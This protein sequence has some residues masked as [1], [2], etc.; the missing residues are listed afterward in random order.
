[1]V[2]SPAGFVTTTIKGNSVD[3]FDGWGT[4]GRLDRAVWTWQ[5]SG[6]I[7]GPGAE[8]NTLKAST[9]DILLSFPSQ[10]ATVIENN[11]INGGGITVTEPNSGGK[12]DI[13]DNVFTQSGGLASVVE[14]SVYIKHHTSGDL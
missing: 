1:A 10:S 13:V 6:S 14:A 11:A 3:A 8:G 2:L 12:V 4:L 7:G 5:A 9:Q